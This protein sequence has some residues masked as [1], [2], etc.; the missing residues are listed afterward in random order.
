MIFF[1]IYHFFLCLSI[2]ICLS[3]GCVEFIK[4]RINL[5][6]FICFN[7]PAFLHNDGND[8]GNGGRKS[9]NPDDDKFDIEIF[10]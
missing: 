1:L 6:T 10:N 2:F 9:R 7:L 4:S 5:S 3:H 8:G